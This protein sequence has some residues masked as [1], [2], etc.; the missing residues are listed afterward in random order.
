MKD[1]DFK[2]FSVELKKL[3]IKLV[4]QCSSDNRHYNKFLKYNI[5]IPYMTPRVVFPVLVL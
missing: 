2:L 3:Q 1:F 4:E 5:N